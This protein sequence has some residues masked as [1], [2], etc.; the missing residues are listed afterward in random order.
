MA[1]ELID[2][3]TET[4]S[5]TASEAASQDATNTTPAPEPTESLADVVQKTA[6]ASVKSSAT[7]PKEGETEAEPEVKEEPKGEADVSAKPEGQA[8]GDEDAETS[9]E[10]PPFHEHPRWQEVQ[11][12]LTDT[13]AE[14]E[15]AKPQ[16]A[17]IKAL[18]DYCKENQI[19]SDD[20]REALVI[21]AL[22]RS[23]PK[24]ALTKM[25]AYTEQ[26][27]TALGE[28]FPADIQKKL[29]DGVIDADT[30][31]ELAQNRLAKLGAESAAKNAQMEAAQRASQEMATAVNSWEESKKKT[32]PNWAQKYQF[33]YDRVQVA[34]AQTP[35]K[36]SAEAISMIEKVYADVT[37]QL[38]SFLPKPPQ[39]KVLTSN[40][41]STTARPT[42]KMDN[43]TTD[44]E[45][46]VR[47]VAA[48]RRT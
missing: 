15:Q 20:L 6:E 8:E 28:R 41:S 44:L 40:G 1:A 32:D 37:K 46:V 30:A 39:K 21:T 4:A 12:K 27:E 33:V 24:Q 36:T 19:S 9:D 2:A 17:R 48:G 5:S 3:N 16:L 45:A 35:P 25:R 22:L 26:V 43:L 11:K 10:Q 18:D 38:S 42:L 29:D 7:E 23:D 13:T 34:L 31:K 14:L 47:H